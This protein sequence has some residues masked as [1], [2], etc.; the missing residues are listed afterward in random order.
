MIDYNIF[1][2]CAIIARNVEI[3]A[4]NDI[5]L[6]RIFGDKKI[7][8]DADNVFDP[9]MSY[10]QLNRINLPSMPLPTITLTIILL[11]NLNVRR[12]SVTVQG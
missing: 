7:Y 8:L 3:D 10:K 9:N 11:R 6:V 12:D 2:E 5:I 1:S 4:T